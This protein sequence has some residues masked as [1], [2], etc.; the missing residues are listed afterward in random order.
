MCK[1]GVTAAV[2]AP[3]LAG[4]SLTV[5]LSLQ[6]KLALLS[7]RDGQQLGGCIGAAA[8]AQ[9]VQDHSKV[10]GVPAQQAG[11]TAGCCLWGVIARHAWKHGDVQACALHISFGPGKM[12]RKHCTALHCAAPTCR[13]RRGPPRPA[14]PAPS[15]R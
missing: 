12:N 13:C 4:P 5:V 6:Q 14:A 15:A 1:L 10:L 9:A 7:A 3:R 2:Q 11:A 8:A